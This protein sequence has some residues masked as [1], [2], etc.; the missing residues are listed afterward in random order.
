MSN[1]DQV[2]AIIAATE[3]AAAREELLFRSDF[4]DLLKDPKFRRWLM[5]VIDHP[6]FC[7][8]GSDPT[9]VESVNATFRRLGQQAIG[10]LLYLR[11]QQLDKDQFLRM[12]AEAVNLRANLSGA[13]P[14]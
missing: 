14:A 4:F 5:H 7:G 11:A 2:K 9:D 8:I 3:D 12:L 10:K 13:S 1:K 6:D